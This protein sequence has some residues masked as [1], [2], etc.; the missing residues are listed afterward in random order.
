MPRRGFSL[1]EIVLVLLVL[2]LVA[3]AVTLRVRPILARMDA[4]A[5]LDEMA[6]F[7]RLSRAFAREQGRPVL[8]LF[9]LAEG[10]VRRTSEDGREALGQ[11]L[12][13]G[14]G[15]RLAEIRLVGRSYRSGRVSVSISGRGL[16]PTYAVALEGA[17]GERR[18][19]LVAGLTGQVM[20]AETDKEVDDA[21]RALEARDHAR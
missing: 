16:G 18:R 17:G 14:P 13:L 6:G 11:A 7:D 20:E 1:I 21:F 2:A 12:D 10:R 3:G 8:L 5:C 15:W 19:F 4:R 9:D